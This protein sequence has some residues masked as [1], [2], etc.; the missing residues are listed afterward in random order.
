MYS[1]EKILSLAPDA[2]SAGKAVECAAPWRWERAEGT[3][4]AVWGLYKTPAEPFTTIVDVQQQRFKCNCPSRKF[5]C[6]HALGLLLMLLEKPDAFRLAHEYPDEVKKWLEVRDK[7][8]ETEKEIPDDTAPVV[9]SAWNWQNITTPQRLEEMLEGSETLENWLLDLTRQG[10]A[11]ALQQ[12]PDLW[13]QMSARMVDSKL[14]GLAKRLRQV[15]AL[16]QLPDWETRLAAELGALFL[17]VRSF[18]KIETLKPAM[19]C[20]LLQI[21]GVNLKKEE[22]LK[23]S[24]VWDD[25]LVLSQVTGTE[26]NLNFRRVWLWGQ[27][28][29]RPALLLDYSFGDAGFDTRW[30][31]AIAFEGEVVFYPGTFPLRALVKTIEVQNK[32]VAEPEGFSSFPDFLKAYAEALSQNPWLGQFPAVLKNVIPAVR[33]HQWYLLDHARDRQLLLQTEAMTGWKLLALS[34]GN[35]LTVFGE[36]DGFVFLP[37]SVWAEGRL[38]EVCD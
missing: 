38:V 1:R 25:W 24:G 16:L 36:W 17:F 20:E 30:Q 27:T 13:L 34:G 7:R 6:K 10:L 5:P 35:P 31:T 21:A 18:K 12:G 14:G 22:V 3:E 19:Q 26:E 2:V 11:Q 15:P 29:L 33:Q 4:R 32:P 28:S 8:K 37:L 23:Q 9:E